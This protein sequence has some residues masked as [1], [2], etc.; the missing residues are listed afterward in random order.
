MT[1]TQERNTYPAAANSERHYTHQL[2]SQLE[3]GQR[4]SQSGW[5]ICCYAAGKGHSKNIHTDQNSMYDSFFSHPVF[6]FDEKFF[7]FDE[8]LKVVILPLLPLFS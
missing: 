8:K 4:L 6:T 5:S 1:L 2:P 7:T 3:Q